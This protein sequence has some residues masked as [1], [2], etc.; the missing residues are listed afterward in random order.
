MEINISENIA[1]ILTALLLLILPLAILFIAVLVGSVNVLIYL[2][3]IF[4]FG[5]GLI[6]YSAIE[7]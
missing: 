4:W 7:Q 5:M 2:L 1:K 3:T 6:F